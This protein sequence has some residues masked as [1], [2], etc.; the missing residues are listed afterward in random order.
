MRYEAAVTSLSWIPSEAITSLATRIPFDAGI[1]HY[2]VPPPDVIED[3][4]ALRA[5]DRFR[6]ANELRAWI[7]VEDGRIVGFGRSGGGLIGSTTLKVGSRRATFEAVALPDLCPDPVVSDTEVTFVQTCGGRTGVPAPRRVRRA[8][9]LQF[10]APLAWTTLRLTLRADG[11]HVHELAGASPF[12]RH[13]IYGADGKLA[14]KSGT[15]DFSSWYRRAF[16]RHSPWGDRD[17][18][19]LSTQIETA[20]ERR[21]SVEFMRGGAKPAVRR[22]KAGQ[23]VVSQGEAGDELFL[24]LDGVVRVEV[25]GRRVAEYGPGSMHGERAVLEG[26]TRTST[27]VAVTDCKVA[28]ARADQLDRD[29]LVELSTG[30]RREE[31]A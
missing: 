9:F 20:L 12:P 19:A 23:P 21:L 15:I 3:L 30:H 26:G 17:S 24:L 28:V 10:S 8:P 5:A 31:G 11:S 27:V 18:P 29:A 16:G 2:D 25:D 13:W 4:D 1:A 14:A 7:E 6:F 22:L